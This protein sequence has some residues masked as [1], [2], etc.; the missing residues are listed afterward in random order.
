MSK[1]TKRTHQITPDELIKE[2]RRNNE[3]R[4]KLEL[5]GYVYVGGMLIVNTPEFVLKNSDGLSLT[6]RARDN[7]SKCALRFNIDSL[8]LPSS[9]KHFGTSDDDSNDKRVDA[10]V[11]SKIHERN[12][13]ILEAQY[14]IWKNFLETMPRKIKGCWEMMGHF[15]S[16]RG[17]T[18]TDFMNKTYLGGFYFER[19]IETRK[20]SKQP[21]KKA[22]ISFAAGYSMPY[23][24]ALKYLEAAGYTISDSDEDIR[25]ALVLCTMPGVSIPKKNAW[26]RSQGATTDELLGSKGMEEEQYDED[27]L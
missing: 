16:E 21:E 4:E 1:A 9:Q 14:N 15:I 8:S 20:A 10:K 27:D 2:Y 22:I 7:F 13:T 12:A 17:I 11:M 5:G 25:Y 18:R 19:A 23:P 24:I 26:L 3:F 6:N